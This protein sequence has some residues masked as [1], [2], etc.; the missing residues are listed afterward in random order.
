VITNSLKYAF[1]DVEEGKI[2]VDL[3]KIENKS[4]EMIIGDDG[5]G[6]DANEESTG[7]GKKLIETFVKQLQGSINRLKHKGTMFK[8]EFEGINGL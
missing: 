7:L 5:I 2:I 4:F 6:L 8:I 1:K 3:R